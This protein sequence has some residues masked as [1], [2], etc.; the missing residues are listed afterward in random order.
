MNGRNQAGQPTRTSSVVTSS[1]EASRKAAESSFRT[2]GNRWRRPAKWMIS[3]W[4]IV[5]FSLRLPPVAGEAGSSVVRFS[6]MRWLYPKHTV[7]AIAPCA[8]VD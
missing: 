2:T 6:A 5:C 7:R 3:P 4:S 1:R 8:A